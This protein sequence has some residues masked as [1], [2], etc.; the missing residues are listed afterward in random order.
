VAATVRRQTRKRDDMTSTK[1][2]LH[3]TGSQ[4]LTAEWEWDHPE[5]ASGEPAPA[6]DG[7]LTLQLDATHGS[8]AITLDRD[9]ATTLLDFLLSVLEDDEDEG[10]AA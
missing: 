3:E 9:Q 2:T 8:A 10:G 1:I 4:I 6:A 7:T 5:N